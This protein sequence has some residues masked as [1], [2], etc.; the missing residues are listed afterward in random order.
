MID[1]LAVPI[2]SGAPIE[3]FDFIQFQTTPETTSGGCNSLDHLAK[4]IYTLTHAD[5]Q[6]LLA[7]RKWWRV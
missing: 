1:F 3:W 6:W 5:I 7:C 2:V 4:V